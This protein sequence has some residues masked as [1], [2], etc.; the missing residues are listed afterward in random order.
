MDP[1]LGV[2]DARARLAVQRLESHHPHQPPDPVP[3]HLRALAAKMTNHLA[4]PVER[5]L[6]VQLVEPTHQRQVL[7][8]R[9]ARRVVQRRATQAKQTRSGAAGSAGAPRVRPSPFAPRDSAPQPA[10]K[11][12]ALHREFPDLRVQRADSLLVLRTTLRPRAGGLDIFN[13]EWT[14]APAESGGAS[15]VGEGAASRGCRAASRSS[16][17]VI[18]GV[19]A[20]A[21]ADVGD[22]LAPGVRRAGFE[23]ARESRRVVRDRNGQAPGRVACRGA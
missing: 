4:A 13:S 8:A 19:A 2:R 5:M 3:T 18:G 9:P 23:Q 16:N 14:G 20:V 15:G 10:K 11:K 7:G 17:E 22:G 12:N 21:L 6:Q 1:M